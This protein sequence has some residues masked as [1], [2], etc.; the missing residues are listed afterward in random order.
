MT[1]NFSIF[2]FFWYSLHLLMKP[3]KPK[4]VAL[5]KYNEVKRKRVLILL[6][7]VDIYNISRAYG[8][9]SLELYSTEF[10]SLIETSFSGSKVASFIV[11]LLF[12]VYSVANNRM[13]TSCNQLQTIYSW[14]EVIKC[15]C[16]VHIYTCI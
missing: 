16:I 5:I 7:F 6:P 14:C 8:E 9:K 3:N 4:F 12:V 10:E 11:V 15:V 2:V 1:F 13:E